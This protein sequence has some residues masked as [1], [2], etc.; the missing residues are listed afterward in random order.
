MF[1][2]ASSLY[3]LAMARQRLGHAHQAR[4]ILADAD[5]ISSEV[6]TNGDWID[7]IQLKVLSEQ[8]TAMIGQSSH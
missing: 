6:D 4:R 1:E 7:A 8:A 5:R 2:F 3:F